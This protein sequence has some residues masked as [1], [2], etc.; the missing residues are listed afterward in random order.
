[1][2]ALFICISYHSEKYSSSICRPVDAIFMQNLGGENMQELKIKFDNIDH[3]QLIGG[4]VRKTA[5]AVFAELKEKPDYLINAGMYDMKSG[6]TVCDTIVDGVL[7][8]GGNYTNKG[9]AWREAAN[10]C[11]NDNGYGAGQ[12]LCIFY[13]RKPIFD[14][15]RKT[16]HRW[17]G[18]YKL[19]SEH[20]EIFAN[21]PRCQ[22]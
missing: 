4:T 20:G 18:V 9:F 5:A 22:R 1:M 15:G 8:N 13:R 6:L 10:T 17:K 16:E 11:S 19:F 12:R 21:R 7:L 3:I 2:V 14:L